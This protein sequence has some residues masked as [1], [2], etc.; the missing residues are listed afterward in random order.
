MWLLCDISSNQLYLLDIA[1]LGYYENN[2]V[3][4]DEWAT[5]QQHNMDS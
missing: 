4:R 3:F 5:R 1:A 2:N